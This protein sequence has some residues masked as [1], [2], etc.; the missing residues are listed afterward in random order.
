MI[1]EHLPKN[2]HGIDNIPTKLERI[3]SSNSINQ[4]NRLHSTLI[5]LEEKCN[6]KVAEKYLVGFLEQKGVNSYQDY[7]DSLV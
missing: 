7:I 4:I 6:M 5:K 1:M 3:K 2:P